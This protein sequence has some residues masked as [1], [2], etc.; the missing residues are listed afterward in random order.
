MRRF[1]LTHLAGPGAAR[2]ALSR[3]GRRFFRFGLVGA[4]GVLVNTL[5]LYLLT[6]VVGWDHLVAAALATEAAI[7]S[8]FLFNDRWTFR[9]ARP[10]LAWPRRLAQ[11]NSISLGGLLIT[12]VVLAAL[13]HL[14]GLYYLV[15]NL[16]AIGAATIWNYTINLRFTWFTTLRP[17]SSTPLLAARPG[18]P[19]RLVALVAL[20]MVGRR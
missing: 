12:L 7:L 3:H 11:Y 9:D 13:S 6:D 19:R 17:E 20:V 4:S 1:E 2:H 14:L 8:N 16:F 18:W 15:A 10:D 5:A